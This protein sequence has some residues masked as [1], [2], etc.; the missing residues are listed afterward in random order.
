MFLLLLCTCSLARVDE[1]APT[2][3]VNSAGY[4]TMPIPTRLKIG[5]QSLRGHTALRKEM[6]LYIFGE[7]GTEAQRQ[8][9]KSCT[10]FNQV[11]LNIS[12]SQQ[13]SSVATPI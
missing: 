1:E 10:Y 13:I 6:W 3:M 2:Q 12:T 7:A 4:S 5:G 9:A 11:Q 8:G